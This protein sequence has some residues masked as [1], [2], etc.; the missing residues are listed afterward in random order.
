MRDGVRKKV[1]LPLTTRGIQCPSCHC[2]DLRV[3]G[4]K[5]IGTRIMRYRYCR[6]CGQ[7][8]IITYEEAAR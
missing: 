3:N 2:R 7:G 6:H 5:R 4:T 1:P 8:P